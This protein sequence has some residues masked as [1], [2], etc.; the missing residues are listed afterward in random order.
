MFTLPGRVLN[1][2][3]TYVDDAGRKDTEKGS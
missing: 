1:A 2:Y 3:E